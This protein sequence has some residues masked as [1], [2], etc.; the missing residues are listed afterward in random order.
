MKTLIFAFIFA[1]CAFPVVSAQPRP[2]EKP[3]PVAAA[4]VPI[5]PAPESFAARY[6]G[7]MIGFGKKETGTLKF[8]D[9]NERMVFF[10]ADRQEK[11]ALPYKSLLAIFPNEKKVT[12]TTGEVVGAVVGSMLGDLIKEKRR[13]LVLQYDDPDV[14][15]KGLAN[16]KLETKE[17]LDSVMKTLGEKAEM[18]QRG[19]AYY[20]PRPATKT[21]SY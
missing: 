4:A 17:L 16:F 8:D 13:Y 9:L 2:I 7:G 3:T 14:D 5:R 18:K 6:E 12:S 1:I 10:G 11:F 19:D 15:A 20:R 21:E